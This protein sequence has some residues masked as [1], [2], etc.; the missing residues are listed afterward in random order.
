MGLRRYP[1]VA[2]NIIS[3]QHVPQVLGPSV[4]APELLMVKL[5]GGLAFP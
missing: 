2:F 5:L 1:L 4:A 3:D